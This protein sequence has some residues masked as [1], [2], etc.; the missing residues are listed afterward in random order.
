MKEVLKNVD[1]V[2]AMQEELYQFKRSKV[3]HQV[4]RPVGRT[5]IGTKWMYRNKHDERGT[6]TRNKVI[7]VVQ[8]YN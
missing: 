7:L 5:I 2:Y 4:P 3:W 8:G 6:I 1:W